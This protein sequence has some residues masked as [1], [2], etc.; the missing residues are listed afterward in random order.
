MIQALNDWDI[1]LFLFLN[2]KHSELLDPIMFWASNKWFWI[3]FYL[4][5]AVW[6]YKKRPKQM[7]YILIAT[8]LLITASDQLSSHVIKPAVLRLRPC[9]N[10]EIAAM[11]HL[12][13]KGCGGSYGF[14]SSHAA[15]SFALA[16]FIGLLALPYSRLVPLI[17]L[18]FAVLVAY[19]RI[20]VGVHYPGDVLC[21]AMVGFG[22]GSLFYF[23]YQR[24]MRTPLRAKLP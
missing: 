8:A 23:L 19:S 2:G 17:L 15:N 7:I 6:L 14:V 3:P 21:G 12:S 20:Y 18:L 16:I 4:L 5:L 10:P 13:P 22:L 11:V 24:L 9:H 1:R